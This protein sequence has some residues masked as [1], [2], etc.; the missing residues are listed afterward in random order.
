MDI[1][2]LLPPFDLISHQ[3]P[4]PPGS[5]DGSIQ[6]HLVAPLPFEEEP[7]GGCVRQARLVVPHQVS[8]HEPTVVPGDQRGVE[9][10]GV[11][12]R[13]GRQRQPNRQG[14][15]SPPPLWEG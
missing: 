15:A 11:V 7:S 10:E 9:Q 6:H 14:K 8:A 13:S 5:G 4:D 1:F 12:L 2:K 3:E